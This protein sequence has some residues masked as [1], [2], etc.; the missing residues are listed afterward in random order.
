MNKTEL[1]EEFIAGYC[2]N[3]AE[4]FH[5]RW[6]NHIPEIFRHGI[7]ETIGGLTSRQATLGLEMAQN[8]GIWNAHVAPIVLRTM[9]DTHITLAWILESPADRSQ[10]YIDYGL[11]QERLNLEYFKNEAEKI[12]EDEFDE[13]L[14]E[15]ID[16]KTSWLD[17]QRYDWAIEV[18]VGAWS[19]KSTRE[20]AKEADCDG[21]YKFA[22]TQFSGA[23]HSM[24]HHVA[25]FNLVPCTNPLHKTHRMPVI[26]SSPVD[27]DY[28]YRSAKY[29]ART[30]SLISEK[31]DLESDVPLPSRYFADNFPCLS[32]EEE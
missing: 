16:F 9:I 5:S 8:P 31:L 7:S 10:A 11:G 21:L 26:L 1:I 18:N 4:G 20:M 3:V 29:V 14:Q 2:A 13:A 23:A 17:A 22:Y 12:P 25:R 6:E 32:K 27:P 19:G 24:W 15:V 28:L 30:Y